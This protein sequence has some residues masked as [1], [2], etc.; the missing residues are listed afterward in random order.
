MLFSDTMGFLTKKM[1]KFLVG[2]K[3]ESNEN[4]LKKDETVLYSNK[5]KFKNDKRVSK[6]NEVLRGDFKTSFAPTS[7]KPGNII[8]TNERIIIAKRGI[9]L[10][11][12]KNKD[13][14][15]QIALNTDALNKNIEDISSYN[16]KMTDWIKEDYPKLY[17]KGSANLFASA[18]LKKDVAT[19]DKSKKKGLIRHKLLLTY[20]VLDNLQIFDAKNHINDMEKLEK[21]LESDNSKKAEE[22]KNLIRKKKG[23]FERKAENLSKLS[24]V[25]MGPYTSKI[26]IKGLHK[27]DLI[28]VLD[29]LSKIN[30][31]SMGEHLKNKEEIEKVY[32]RS[33]EQENK[34]K[35][36]ELRE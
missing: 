11:N 21:E 27:K 7:F 4:M 9:D 26:L 6:R 29:L 33:N 1:E 35:K 31:S 20:Q 12:L 5:I 10:N 8:I 17:I 16:K 24:Q 30:P 23:K 28:Q 36:S 3:V 18:L 14:Y 2:D 22:Y 25:R 32:M 34:D 15:I 13:G 19:F